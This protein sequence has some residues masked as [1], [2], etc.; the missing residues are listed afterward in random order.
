MTAALHPAPLVHIAT[1]RV[2]ERLGE[3]APDGAV[4]A[5]LGV[6]IRTILRWR[7]SPETALKPDTADRC[8][9]AL[10][11]HWA[12]IWP[13][14]AQAAYAKIIEDERSLLQVAEVEALHR[15]REAAKAK[16]QRWREKNRERVRAMNRRYYAENAEFYRAEARRR[17][18]RIDPETGL[19]V[20]AAAM[21]RWRQASP[22]V[23]GHVDTGVMFHDE[24]ALEVH[25]V[26][27]ARSGQPQ[28][29]VA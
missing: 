23:T 26:D 12:E 25:K 15:R 11:L 17:R 29:E 21:R 19:T 22:I 6:T 13:E 20:G 27:A 9:T 4:A 14:V 5:E 3:T 16:T 7:Q 1:I 24:Q 2:S 8:A 28:Q 18:S 10:G